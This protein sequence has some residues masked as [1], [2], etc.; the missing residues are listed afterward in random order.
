M[1]VCVCVYVKS[2]KITTGFD[3]LRD[4]LNTGKVNTGDGEWHVKAEKT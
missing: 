1:I 2:N 4:G 3:V